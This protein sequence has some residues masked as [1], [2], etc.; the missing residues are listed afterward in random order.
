MTH[1]ASADHITTDSTRT[2]KT[3][4]AGWGYGHTSLVFCAV[5]IGVLIVVFSTAYTSPITVGAIAWLALSVTFTLGGLQGARW[6]F[7]RQ[8]AVKV[9]ASFGEDVAALEHHTIGT[10]TKLQEWLDAEQAQSE[11]SREARERLERVERVLLVV[12]ASLK[13]AEAFGDRL[14]AIEQ[15]MNA[16]ARAVRELAEQQA[17]HVSASEVR[18]DGFAK[19][20]AD[21]ERRIPDRA[22]VVAQVREQVMEQIRP[23]IADALLQ[24]RAVGFVDALDGGADSRP[25]NV[26]RLPGADLR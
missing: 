10:A 22:Q 18:L 1:S 7:G 3:D 17:R 14:T 19:L 8:R 16:L 11:R 20:L 25:K 12:S 23:E 6:A 5:G 13:D 26:L 21:V 15:G 2:A 24:A 9:E 4:P